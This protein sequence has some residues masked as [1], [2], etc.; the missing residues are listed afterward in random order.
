MAGAAQTL[1]AER[2]ARALDQGDVVV[3]YQPC[4]DL[5]T[6]EMVA[7]EALARILD[8][9]SGEL[10]EPSGFLDSL[11]ESGLVVRLD[12]LVLSAAA[13][14]VARWRGLPAGRRLCLAVNLSP[15]DLDDSMLPQ[16]FR[17]VSEN[18]GLPLDAVIVELTETVLSRTG[19]GHEQVL[20]ELA[21]L[22]CNVT[23]D[24]FGTGNAS[25]DYLRRFRVDGVKIDRSFVQFLGSGGPHE[26]MAE[27]L[28]RFCLSLGVHVVA[29]GIERPQHVAA[30]RRLGCP[31]GQGFLMSRPL[32]GAALE[33]LLVA[34]RVPAALA[35]TAE[36]GALPALTTAPTA[37]EPSVLERLV[38]RVLAGLVSLVLVLVAVLV[39][40]GR[41]DSDASLTSAARNRLEAID[42]LAA[43]G[44]D[45]RLGGL[46]DAV[47]T[48]SR[49]DA[50]RRAVVTG[51]QDRMD[52]ALEA[53][54]SATTGSYNASLYDASGV[55]LDLAPPQRS[56]EV[57]G[58]DFSFREWYLPAG[59][60]DTAYVSQAYQLMTPER[61][62]AVAVAAA[63]RDPR[64]RI[65]GYVV[66]TLALSGLQA[67]MEAVFRRYG[68]AVT[69]VDRHG[70]T[71]ADSGGRIGVPTSDPRLLGERGRG[72]RSG[73]GERLWA[74]SEVSSIGGWLL[75]E[76][77]RDAA[78]G[79]A[80]GGTDPLLAGLVVAIGFVLVLLWLATDA[81]RRRLKGDLRRANAWLSSILGATPTPVLVSDT[82]GRVHQAN[83]AAAGLLGVPADSLRGQT[84]GSWLTTRD[85]PASDGGAFPATVVT[86]DGDVRLVEVQLRDLT[87]PH[88]EPMRLHSLVDVT[89]HREEQDRLRAQSRIDP[90]TGVANRI[91][92]Q[93]ALAAAAAPGR[94]PH[95]L[96]ML[97]L[98]RFKSVND[99]LGHAA[100]DSVLCAVAD[101]LGDAVQPDD[102]VARVGGDEFVLVVRLDERTSPG[103]VA[104]RLRGRV[105]EV[106]DAHPFALHVPVG[107]S[108]GSAAVG[109]DGRDADELLRLADAR[110]YE[111]K[112]RRR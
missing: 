98:D 10:V 29:E 51:D 107:V 39:V 93:E 82:D 106:L 91:G 50:V 15:A 19:Q 24:D 67:E 17:E 43:R 25:F 100:G 36:R 95:A 5:R 66:A 59:R 80:T 58:H 73:T 104:E 53:L 99:D 92:L 20:A 6:G 78:V 88:G 112:R 75:V 2:I 45:L 37:A 23:L 33:A 70:T 18:S 7:V 52:L 21:G 41:A 94:S 65:R 40:E 97:D 83:A 85:Q 110:M 62:W 68:V 55:M 56:P 30:L 102:T 61:T 38:P 60:R 64:G 79:N 47:T 31:F 71:L 74:V 69:V 72:D 57:I 105:Q 48:F 77:D 14:Q 34:D 101:V 49:S 28:V 8:T 89:P 32:D 81:R 90:L 4:Y 9:E 16:R 46:R 42:S 109:A 3:H 96:V 103:V 76:Q 27:S 1:T 26:R 84:V 13:G 63:V 54:G 44:V 12:E 86:R 35:R 87:G 22:G 11:E 111:A 108:V